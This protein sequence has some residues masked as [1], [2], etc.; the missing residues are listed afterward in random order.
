VRRKMIALLVV[1]LTGLFSGVTASRADMP[2]VNTYWAEVNAIVKAAGV[3]PAGEVATFR[4]QLEKAV[5][6][7][8]PPR[9]GLGSSYKR[10]AE[11]AVFGAF[12][13]L[14]KPHV[15][16]GELSKV[17]G[18]LKTVG[19][20]KWIQGNL[21]ARNGG[22]FVTLLEVTAGSD[23]KYV[24]RQVNRAVNPGGWKGTTFD[25]S[26]GVAVKW[27]DAKSPTRANPTPAR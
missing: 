24:F 27:P 3:F 14:V 17:N 12:E 9:A 22:D 5:V 10:V 13:A 1:T 15:E 8:G 21:R 7:G 25:R 16:K 2:A 23:G 18:F 11:T 4:A 20:G 19:D 26:L 6:R